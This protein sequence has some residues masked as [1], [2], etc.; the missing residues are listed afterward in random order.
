MTYKIKSQEVKNLPPLE[1]SLWCPP[2]MIT[3]S[4]VI[5]HHGAALKRDSF[6][7]LLTV[8]PQWLDTSVPVR[9]PKLSPAR[10]LHPPSVQ[11]CD[12]MC[13]S[14]SWWCSMHREF[15]ASA[16]GASQR[17]DTCRLCPERQRQPGLIKPL[18]DP[19]LRTFSTA[20][21]HTYIYK[22]PL[23]DS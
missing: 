22:R 15:G 17:S 4:A 1:A 20:L 2:W 6:Q 9:T 8:S 16:R 19:Q 14:V 13:R 11:K 21:L 5:I 12:R 23:P 7:R 18:S 3:F 10:R